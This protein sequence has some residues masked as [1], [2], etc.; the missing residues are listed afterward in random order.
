MIA[1]RELELPSDV[2]SEANAMARS[3]IAIETDLDV[4]ELVTDCWELPQ[5]DPR[6]ST[7]SF[8]AVSIKKSEASHVAS[9]LLRAGFECQ[10]MDAL[11]CAIARSTAM[12]IIDSDISTLSVDLGYQQ[13]TLTLVKAGRPIMSR[14]L[15]GLGLIALLDQ[16]AVSFE[17]SR[18]DAQ[19]LLFQPAGNTI[20]S[21]SNTFAFSNPIHQHLSSFFQVLSA[22]IDKTIQYTNRAYR[23]AIPGHLLLMG[24][25]SCIA[26]LDRSLAD[27]TGLPASLW[28]ID[29]S[30]GLFA[31]HHS[32]VYAV[33]A[34]LSTLAWEQV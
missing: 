32:S 18:S 21:D 5:C 27:R 19:T 8:G 17:L 24:A 12:V 28:R 26:N 9:S 16:I 6:A 30:D 22:E 11:P 10:T 20:S 7:F 25:G 23:S 3:E 2:P 31:H 14:E 33:A 4:E 34:G 13:T 29:L 1:Y 15:R